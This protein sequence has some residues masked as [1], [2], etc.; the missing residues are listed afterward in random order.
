MELIV[1]HLNLFTSF[2]IVEVPPPPTNLVVDVVA[3]CDMIKKRFREKEVDQQMKP[4]ESTN[5]QIA[6]FKTSDSYIAN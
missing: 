3:P 2:R 1:Y 4:D 5:F 6:L